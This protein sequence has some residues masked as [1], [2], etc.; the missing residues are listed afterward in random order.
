ML[1]CAHSPPAAAPSRLLPHSVQPRPSQPTAPLSAAQTTPAVP[2]PPGILRAL[3][4]PVGSP[5]MN[6]RPTRRSCRRHS[7]AP[8]PILPAK[9]PAATLPP[10]CAPPPPSALPQ[11]PALVTLA[12]LLSHSASAAIP[13]ALHTPPAPCI[14]VTAP[15]VAAATR[16]DSTPAL[17]PQPPAAPRSVPT[18]PTARAAPRTAH[19][20][21]TSCAGRSPPAVRP[22]LPSPDNHAAPNSRAVLLRVL[23]SL[24]LPR[25]APP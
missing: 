20:P 15:P 7:P 19:A 16:S 5:A 13:P 10:A 18:G 2:L 11:P 17:R 24:R 25:R 9:L 23:R 14:P 21:H 8:R 22:A 1:P 6:A 12:C 4:T 3:A